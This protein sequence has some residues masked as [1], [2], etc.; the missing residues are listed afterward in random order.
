MVFFMRYRMQPTISRRR[1]PI[2]ESHH[3]HFQP[4][5]TQKEL[6]ARQHRWRDHLGVIRVDD[7]ADNRAAARLFDTIVGMLTGSTEMR[8]RVM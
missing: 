3:L 2:H 6:Q 4:T 8:R 5:L 1:E 7:T